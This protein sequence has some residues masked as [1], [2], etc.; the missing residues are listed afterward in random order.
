MTT[1]T[2]CNLGDTANNSTTVYNLKMIHQTMLP[3]S[4]IRLNGLLSEIKHHFILSMKGHNIYSE[5]FKDTR[6]KLKTYLR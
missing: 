5:T 6:R 3:T 4:T 2:I 1:E